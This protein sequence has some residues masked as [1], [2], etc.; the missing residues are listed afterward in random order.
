MGDSIAGSTVYSYNG[1]ARNHVIPDLGKR[2][3]TTIEANDIQ[4]FIDR[5]ADVLSVKSCKRCEIS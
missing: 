5:K 4:E 1:A 3:L 2:L